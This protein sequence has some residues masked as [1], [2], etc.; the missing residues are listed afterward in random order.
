MD[1]KIVRVNDNHKV[2]LA[3]S[4]SL[5]NITN[6][7]LAS[8]N[9]DEWIEKLLEWFKNNTIQEKTHCPKIKEELIKAKSISLR[10]NRLKEVPKEFFNLKQLEILE[11]NNK[12]QALSE[13]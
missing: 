4:K 5:L 12:I 13:K 3:K 1:K 7:I 10:W 9:D 2:V 6:K 11:L 8:K